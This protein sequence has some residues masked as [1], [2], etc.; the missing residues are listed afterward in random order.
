[1]ASGGFS[2][3]TALAALGVVAAVAT[4]LYLAHDSAA[5]DAT[6]S[7]TGCVIRFTSE[8]PRIHENATHVCNGASSIRVQADGDLEIKQTSG[9]PIVSVTV[10]EDET[11]STRGI[12]AG[13]SGGVGTTV[14]KLFATRSEQS[15]DADSGGL[16][17]GNIWVT[18]VQAG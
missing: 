4:P 7:V 9:A 14:V 3:L 10:D 16:T 15:V 17:G 6:T 12:L 18:W 5:G 2:R 13:A 1:M 11:L 8:G